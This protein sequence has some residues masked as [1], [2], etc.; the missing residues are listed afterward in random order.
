MS[1]K[2]EFVPPWPRADSDAGLA[3]WSL[4]R[5]A[6]ALAQYPAADL[7]DELA[8]LEAAQDAIAEAIGRARQYQERTRP[9]PLLERMH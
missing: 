3:A 6:E 8:T 5:E 9:L 4:E 7:A 1:A 2:H